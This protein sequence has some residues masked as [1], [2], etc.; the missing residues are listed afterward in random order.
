MRYEWM[1]IPIYIVNE[2]FVEIYDY[3]FVLVPIPENKK[4]SLIL[5]E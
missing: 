2:E 1:K 3:H 4:E 5:E